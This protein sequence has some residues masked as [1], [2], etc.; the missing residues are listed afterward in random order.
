MM[1]HTAYSTI[2]FDLDGTLLDTWPGLLQTVRDAAP[3][4]ARLDTAALRRALSLG[5]APMF[6]HAA[7][8]LALSAPAAGAFLARRAPRR[9]LRGPPR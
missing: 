5:I 1:H 3:A 9:P 7:A 4:Q 8:Q 6:E 2:I